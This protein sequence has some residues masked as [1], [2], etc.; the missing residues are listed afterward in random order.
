MKLVIINY[1]AGNIKSIQFAFKRLGVDAV[2]S[3]DPEEILAAEKII[4]PG[5]GEASSAMAMLEESGL[6]KL[7][8]KLKQPV[9]GICLGMQ[10]LCEF[11]EEGNTKGLGVFK[12]VVKR[13]DNSVKVPQMGWNVI[14]ELKSNL[15][16]DVKEKEYMYLVHSYYA[17]HC[18]ETIATT[19]YGLN[20]ASALQH[21]NFYG[22]QF[23]PEKS[24]LAGE[25]ILKNFLEL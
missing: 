17:E 13:F 10:L 9:L 2:L 21:K 3:N 7:I 1:G 25:Q 18:P 16:K 19:D 15:F 14:K 6:D 12:T 5:V 8:P 11:T 24:S 22:V 20:Y 23:H 4:F